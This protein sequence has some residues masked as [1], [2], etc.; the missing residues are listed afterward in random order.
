[1]PRLLGHPYGIHFLTQSLCTS[2][3][4]AHGTCFWGLS[5]HLSPTTVKL[6]PNAKL[7]CCT[8]ASTV[9]ATQCNSQP[10]VLFIKIVDCPHTT[11]PE[12]NDVRKSLGV[13]NGGGKA[14]GR[15][16]GSCEIRSCAEYRA[17]A[18]E[19]MHR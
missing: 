7:C 19:V 2:G 13:S 12:V 6:A 10:L 8:D 5:D 14:Q 16:I 9:S 3:T 17:Q 1:M 11:A 4:M 15:G 18:L